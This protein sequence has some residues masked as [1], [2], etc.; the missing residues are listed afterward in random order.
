M[1]AV[2]SAWILWRCLERQEPQRFIEDFGCA[3]QEGRSPSHQ[4]FQCQRG[5]ALALQELLCCF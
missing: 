1:A 4:F 3:V 5:V 2:A